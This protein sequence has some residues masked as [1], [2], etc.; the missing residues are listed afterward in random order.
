MQLYI[1]CLSTN[2]NRQLVSCHG[3]DMIWTRDTWHVPKEKKAELCQPGLI[4]ACRL[5]DFPY[6]ISTHV[7]IIETQDEAP[8]IGDNKVGVT[9]ARVLRAPPAVDGLDILVRFSE[10]VA[11][12]ALPSTWSTWLQEQYPAGFFDGVEA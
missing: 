1:K 2:A 4:H 7:A 3:G 5:R 11:S 12:G 8:V 6:W 9:S 10:Y